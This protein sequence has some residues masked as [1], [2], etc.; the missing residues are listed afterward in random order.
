MLGF[1]KNIECKLGQTKSKRTIPNKIACFTVEI[2]NLLSM[3]L[4]TLRHQDKILGA[5]TQKQSNT[6]KSTVTSTLAF[7]SSWSTTFKFCFALPI[8]IIAPKR[9][10]REFKGH[11]NL[12]TPLEKVIVKIGKGQLRN[13]SEKPSFGGDLQN[14]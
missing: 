10:P 12:Q 9:Q 13:A 11:V 6:R 3:F 7:P 2:T 14:R 4:F 8:P 1:Y 5:E